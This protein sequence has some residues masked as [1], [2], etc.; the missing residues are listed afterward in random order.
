MVLPLDANYWQ[1]GQRWSL[2]QVRGRRRSAAISR[3][4]HGCCTAVLHV[5]LAAG[6][7][8]VRDD[9]DMSGFD[10]TFSFDARDH[11]LM[12]AFVA[13][14]RRRAR[15]L[16]VQWRARLDTN[17]SGYILIDGRGVG[18]S[19]LLERMRRD[20]PTIGEAVDSSRRS[21]E[22]RR[23][24]ANGFVDI[25]IKWHTSFYDNYYNDAEILERVP[26]VR[27]IKASAVCVAFWLWPGDDHPDLG[28]R[29]HVTEDILVSWLLDEASSEVV[30]EEMHT[31][32]E[33]ILRRLLGRQRDSFPQLVH[34]AQ[35]PGQ[36]WV[37]PLHWH[38]SDEYAAD[39]PDMAGL[40]LS[41]TGQ[42]NA[43]KH[44]G[45][46]GAREWLDQHFWAAA[47]TLERL[48]DLLGGRP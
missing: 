28:V 21:P 47:V 29:L 26:R 5:R 48:A 11:D 34:R 38:Y 44:E 30:L 43:A 14:G 31:A 3:C 15:K 17:G 2:A 41:L 20:L 10:A 12:C 39:A 7:G 37:R 46:K 19:M 36:P 27:C 9:L 16:Q 13:A 23:R 1:C 18:E 6:L 40:L 42:R 45:A 32:A 24:L 25:L 33:L 35:T 8:A 4:R 22:Q